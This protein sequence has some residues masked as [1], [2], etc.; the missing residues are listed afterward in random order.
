MKWKEVI[1]Y[2]EQHN[3]TPKEVDRRIKLLGTIEF[4]LNEFKEDENETEHT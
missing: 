4:M 2:C 1:E 3:I